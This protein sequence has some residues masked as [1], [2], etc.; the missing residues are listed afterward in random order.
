M[1]IAFGAGELVAT[2]L[3]W[4][5]R[6]VPVDVRA[7]VSELPTSVQV[8]HLMTLAHTR[9]GPPL[10]DQ[11]R[12]ALRNFTATPEGQ[13]FFRDTG[14]QGYDAIEPFDLKALQPYVPIV[15]QM[16]GM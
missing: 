3:A 13:M 8:P 10:V 11:V 7:K 16:M 9:L 1:T 12:Q 15:K 5:P 2:G 4:R 6:A 14:Y